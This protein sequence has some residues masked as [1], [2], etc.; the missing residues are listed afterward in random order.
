M[1][2]QDLIAQV[3]QSTPSKIIFLVIDG[4]GG[5]PHPDTGKSELETAYTPNLDRLAARAMCGLTDPVAPGI[6]PGSGPGHL[7]LFGYDPVKSLIKRG[8][9]EAAGIGLDMGPDDLAVRGNF[10]TVDKNGA[11]T[12]RRAGRLPTE[13]SRVLCRQMDRI[14]VSGVEIE[15]HPVE[16]HRF[17]IIFKGRGLS[18]ELA[19][20][21]QQVTGVTPPPV[22]ALTQDAVS[23]AAMVN[24]F[25]EKARGVLGNQP[26]A[27]MITLRG[28]SKLPDLAPMK[29][30][31]K[32]NPVALATYPMYRGLARLL[33]M[34]YLD[35]GPTFE[36][37]VN[38][39]V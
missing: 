17:V 18:D 38:D 14:Q 24:E 26:K 6:T 31:Y 39:L 10:C 19:D 12:H 3:A 20:T 28:F 21:D 13:E 8:V 15:V 32:L 2:Q 36:D 25:V 23:S 16:S 9:L 1:T 27:N 4:L 11:I 7:A 22:K 37:Q 34:K 35:T 33:G 30:V 29:Q 5:L